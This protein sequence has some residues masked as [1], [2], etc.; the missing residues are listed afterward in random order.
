MRRSVVAL[1]TVCLLMVGATPAV[2]EEETEG[3]EAASFTGTSVWK[4]THRFG[5]TE[6]GEGWTSVLGRGIRLELRDMD[7]PRL[8]GQMDVKM[9]AI[10]YESDGSVA[11]VTYRIDNNAGSWLGTGNAYRAGV[12]E[13]PRDWTPVT[14]DMALFRGTGAYEGLS[15]LMFM[16]FVGSGY[17]FHGMVFPGEFP[18]MPEYPE[19]VE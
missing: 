5:D 11:S 18:E 3:R 13:E 12:V 2:S 17:Q 1:V 19:P 9:N 6:T 4:V 7:D 14:A 15:A 8:N 16:D 10:Q